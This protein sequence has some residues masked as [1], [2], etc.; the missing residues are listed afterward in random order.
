MENTQVEKISKSSNKLKKT[1][2]ICILGLLLFLILTLVYEYFRIVP[3][4]VVFSNVTSSSVT[5]SWNTKSPMSATA[6]YK[7]GDGG[8]INLFGIGKQVFYDT[9]D[10]VK[11]ELK[12]VEQTS[13]NIA[14]S[15]DISVSMSE[16]KTEVKVTDKGKYY[17]HHV[18]I[19]GLDPE[20]EYSFFVGDELLYRA[21]KDIDGNTMVKT[22]KVA[23]SIDTPVPAY[24]SVKDAQNKEGIKYTDLTP[25]KDAVV[26]INYLDDLT[27]TTSNQFS[28]VLNED[29][30]WYVDLSTAVDSE[31]NLFLEKYDTEAKNLKI[32]ITLNVGPLG[33]WR[34][35]QN[36]YTIAPAQEIVINM[37]NGVTDGSIEGS[38]IKLSQS[39]DTKNEDVKGVMAGP[40]RCECSKN[41]DGTPKYR[42]P[43]GYDFNCDAGWNCTTVSSVCTKYDS[44]TTEYCGTQSGPTCY[45][46]VSKTKCNSCTPTCPSG[47]DW[48]CPSGKE[49][50]TIKSSCVPLD[51]NGNPCGDR[52]QGNTCYKVKK[53]PPQQTCKDKIVSPYA[54][55]SSCIYYLSFS[56]SAPCYYVDGCDSGGDPHYVKCSSNFCDNTGIPG[57]DCRKEPP[58][59]DLKCENTNIKVGTYGYVDS[60]CK[61]CEWTVVNNYG[62][63]GLKLIDAEDKNCSPDPKCGWNNGK[64]FPNGTVLTSNLCS[65]GTADS[66]TVRASG[67][68]YSWKCKQ[69]TKEISCSATVS[70][71]TPDQPEAPIGCE[72]G[73]IQDGGKKVCNGEEY[74]TI[75]YRCSS[76]SRVANGWY[77]WDENGDC[78]LY[79]CRSPY[80]LINGQCKLNEIS[81]DMPCDAN[82]DDVYWIHNKV[83][84]RCNK[85]TYKWEEYDPWGPSN[86]LI[87]CKSLASNQ[88]TNISC[89]NDG[90]RCIVEDKI[91]VCSNGSF[92]EDTGQPGTGRSPIVFADLAKE[93]SQGE[94]CKNGNKGCTCK[95]NDRI[96]ILSEAEWCP[97]KC[98]KEGQ[99]CSIDG[100]TCWWNTTASMQPAHWACTGEI[101][102]TDDQLLDTLKR[103][104]CRHV[105]GNCKCKNGPDEGLVISSDQYCVEVKDC[106]NDINNIGKICK[107]D[108]TTC[109]KYDTGTAS[110]GIG[111]VGDKPVNDGQLKEIIEK[112]VFSFNLNV[113]FPQV[114][115]QSQTNTRNSQFLI[116]QAEGMFV[117]IQDGQYVFEYEGEKYYFSINEMSGSAKVVIDK[118]NNQQYD[119]GTDILVS[120]L[121]STIQIEP[122]E[123]K[124][125]YVLKQGFNFVSFP[126]LVS[127]QEYRT[128]ASLLKKLNDIYED[129]IYSI[130]K[131]DGSWKVVGQNEELYSANDFQLLP[132]Q[133]YVIKAKDDVTIDIWG[134]PIKYDNDSPNAPVALFKGWNL[135]G[136]YGT[137]IKQYTAK[138]LL[139]DINKYEKVDFSAD[140]VSKWDNELQR[141]EGFQISDK[142]GVPTE[143]GF[144][145]LINLL[146]SY[147]VRVQ[148]GE[149]NWQPELA[150]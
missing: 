40:C 3:E 60:K 130:A 39:D 83:L 55:K 43:S 42:C 78:V 89:Y 139:E 9:R 23:E 15:E 100:K 124:Y 101:K 57:L 121:A 109:A 5:V 31:G 27:G 116:D 148:D 71:E 63:Y 14:K 87:K 11:A 21:V 76:D 77:H 51:D 26:Y 17:T 117:N 125:T 144:D 118:N 20:T 66:T 45:K 129:S 29:G 105:S 120:D 102:I 94:V 106:N 8:F 33:I 19:K 149:G 53:T 61:L 13:K 96:L 142:N 48:Q 132:G 86:D 34:Q 133:G 6:V 104:P 150:Q 67:S 52:I 136:L 41:P 98:E 12:A 82:D 111:C 65:S 10:L 74:V 80:I 73:T 114:L 58:Q 24:S 123:L 97:E 95:Y 103:E 112:K 4:N 81:V 47:F 110:G 69:G 127:N 141:Y 108:G 90:V 38:V 92:I 146:N 145:Y 88:T 126:F 37:A 64:S 18:E 143:Y 72:K 22:A 79:N 32:I 54:T 128:A 62:G 30:N 91:Y 107:N 50:T 46:E 68:R 99:V 56:C 122:I 75:G 131:Y 147:F 137:G 135:V 16:V 113:D 138:T 115:A 59:E 140:N 1:L 85:V 93:I 36:A 134:K 35:W 44:C 84:Y 119:E 70:S 25:V 7:K 28:A 2:S 49:C